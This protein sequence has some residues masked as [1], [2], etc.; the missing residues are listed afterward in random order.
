MLTTWA[1]NQLWLLRELHLR[2]ACRLRSGLEVS[3]LHDYIEWTP[4]VLNGVKM[5]NIGERLMN[6][7]LGAYSGDGS[8]LGR[9]I[10]VCHN[11][12]PSHAL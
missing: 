4:Q 10:T 6:M 8:W 9:S 1:G 12:Y 5:D 11:I 7:Q 2:R 3:P